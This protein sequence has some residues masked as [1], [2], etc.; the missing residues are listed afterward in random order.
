MQGSTHSLRQIIRTRRKRQRRA[1]AGRVIA[2]RYSSHAG[3]IALI[4]SDFEHRFHLA[5]QEV[6]A[7]TRNAMMQRLTREKEAALA[8]V[9]FESAAE[10][11]AVRVERRAGDQQRYGFNAAQVGCCKR[12]ALPRPSRPELRWH[13]RRVRICPNS[14]D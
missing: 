10:A 8:R 3:E 1:S 4:H 7:T 6:C 9:R 2:R 13:L 12:Q 14:I 11:L 5:M